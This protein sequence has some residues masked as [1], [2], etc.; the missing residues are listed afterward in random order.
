MLYRKNLEVL[1]AEDDKL[2]KVEKRGLEADGQQE[3]IKFCFEF[4]AIFDIHDEI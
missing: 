4:E 2:G 3:K 1:P